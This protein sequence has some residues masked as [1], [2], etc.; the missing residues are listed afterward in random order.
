MPI[1]TY[2]IHTETMTCLLFYHDPLVEP[3]LGHLVR[4]TLL[5]FR[6]PHASSSRRCLFDSHTRFSY[7]F[8]WS[9]SYVWWW[10]IWY[11]LIFYLPYL[12]CHTRAYSVSF[13]DLWIFMDLHEHYHLLDAHWAL[14]CSL[15]YH[16]ILVDPLWIH[17][18]RS[19]FFGIW[20]PPCFIFQ[21]TFPRCLDLIW[22]PEIT[23][24]LIDDFMSPNF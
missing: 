7:G 10:M 13:R 11:H 16:D 22:N 5:I 23:Y 4:P 19:S 1:S 21:D 14:T 8:G 18:A 3:R 15:P 9:E 24:S 2:E 20:L 12:W 6:C 17:L